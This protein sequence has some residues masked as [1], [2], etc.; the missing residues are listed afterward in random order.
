MRLLQDVNPKTATVRGGHSTWLRKVTFS[1]EQVK[2]LYQRMEWPLERK[3]V[4]RLRKKL[5]MYLH[6]STHGAV[7]DTNEKMRDMRY[8][9]LSITYYV[10]LI[11][12]SDLQQS[13]LRLVASHLEVVS[14]IAHNLKMITTPHETGSLD[15]SMI[16][17]FENAILPP[18]PMRAIEAGP[19][20]T[21][22]RI[23]FG[24]QRQIELESY[25]SMSTSSSS[26][27]EVGLLG[28]DEVWL[29]KRLE[30]IAKRG[31]NGGRAGDLVPSAGS[32]E[33]RYSVVQPVLHR[34]RE[35]RTGFGDAVGIPGEL[36]SDDHLSATLADAQYAIEEELGKWNQ[37]EERIQYDVKRREQLLNM[38]PPQLSTRAPPI[39]RKPVGSPVILPQPSPSATGPIPIPI[40]I[41]SPRISPRMSPQGSP[42]LSPQLGLSPSL[43]SESWFGS[44]D[45]HRSMHDRS[46]STSS[47]SR[48]NSIHLPHA[49]P[50]VL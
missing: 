42:M 48:A 29:K 33:R 50:V 10:I 49:F 39:I 9:T 34:L 3:E 1:R 5:I 8:A 27:Q 40:S 28:Q 24:G 44:P 13:N 30:N 14:S 45:S 38:A 41:P 37:L 25:A 20:Q 16:R 4:A 23:Q 11:P 26:S 31:M 22:L 7:L 12:I 32:G 19:A 2:L 46:S 47:S 36:T 35:I 17:Q 6:I 18:P 15:Y 43:S 21:P